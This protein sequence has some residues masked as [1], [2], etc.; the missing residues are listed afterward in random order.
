MLL[1]FLFFFSLFLN[2]FLTLPDA[3]PAYPGT[4]LRRSLRGTC[5]CCRVLGFGSGVGAEEE[6]EGPVWDGVH[7]P[8][9][10]SAVQVKICRA[11]VC[12][13]QEL[14][15]VG[16]GRKCVQEKET[17]SCKTSI[18]RQILLPDFLLICRLFSFP[19]T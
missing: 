8:L 14:V 12:K 1:L 11:G 10:D 3:K 17:G 4:G 18:R 16:K 5:L 7:P 19:G 2:V 9:Q 13:V 6:C 15:T